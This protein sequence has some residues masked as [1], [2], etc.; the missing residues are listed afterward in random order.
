MDYIFGLE[1]NA[2]KNEAVKEDIFQDMT[3]ES[4]RCEY[5]A[6]D[7][8]YD[9]LFSH[10]EGGLYE[11]RPSF[12]LSKSEAEALLMEYPEVCLI[13]DE[14]AEG[15]QVYYAC[16]PRYGQFYL[17]EILTPY[18]D[19]PFVGCEYEQHAF[20]KEIAPL[21]AEHIDRFRDYSLIRNAQFVF[22]DRQYVYEDNFEFMPR[23]KKRAFQWIRPAEDDDRRIALGNLI[24]EKIEEGIYFVHDPRRREFPGVSYPVVL[25]R[26]STVEFEQLPACDGIGVLCCRK[27]DAEFA[28]DHEV[29][30]VEYVK[31][32]AFGKEHL[33]R[34]KE[35]AVAE[36]GSYGELPV[37]PKDAKE[38]IPG[39]G[40]FHSKMRY[41]LVTD[42]YETEPMVDIAYMQ[43]DELVLWNGGLGSLYEK[44]IPFGLLESLVVT[45]QQHL[46]CG[47]VIGV[48]HEL[49][50]RDEQLKMILTPEAYELYRRYK[51]H[52]FCLK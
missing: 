12:W 32:I 31:Y 8:L 11:A 24:C 30:C 38:L 18:E 15:F 6:T 26:L 4:F 50:N 28:E 44:R 20:M 49:L 42:M 33:P 37:I 2:T 23:P 22:R 48:S 34:L 35:M 17:G 9:H 19:D 39:E 27:N 13:V 5:P 14:D 21:L 29:E 45:T 1:E 52:D 41:K 10:I 40:Y 36:K 7:R 25:P 3:L 16:A 43:G 51:F 46:R 47:E